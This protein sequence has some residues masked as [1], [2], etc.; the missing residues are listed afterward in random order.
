MTRGNSTVNL[1]P[2]TVKEL[3]FEQVRLIRAVPLKTDAPTQ[4][5]WRQ[6]SN[7]VPTPV[8]RKKRKQPETFPPPLVKPSVSLAMRMSIT[9]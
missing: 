6:Q 8:E 9:R 4:E 1:W 2:L 7:V 5:D 3:S